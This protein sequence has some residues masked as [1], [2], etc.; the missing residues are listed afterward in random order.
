MAT[1]FLDFAACC[2]RFLPGRHKH[3]AIP[4]EETALRSDLKD[5][6]CLGLR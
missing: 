1:F 5:Q 6:S 3:V 4:W 2:V